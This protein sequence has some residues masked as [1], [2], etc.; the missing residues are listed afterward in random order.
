MGNP[1][2]GA[3]EFRVKD[4]G[5]SS[6]L[7]KFSF[8]EGFQFVE[9]GFRGGLVNGKLEFGTL[10]GSEHHEAHDTFPVHLFFIFFDEDLGLIFICDPH[11]HGGG[12]RVDA[13][14]IFNFENPFDGLSTHG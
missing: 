4:L 11:D 6:G 2:E 12:P 9:H 8:K 7:F 13:E 10:T 1:P 3:C 5:F 14:L